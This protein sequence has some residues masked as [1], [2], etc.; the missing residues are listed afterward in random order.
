MDQ[1]LENRVKTCNICQQ[2]RPADN[3]VPVHPWEFP[4][5]PWVRFHLDYAGPVR[6]KMYLVL[7]DAYSK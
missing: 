5:R 4:K 3:P 1:E 7:I 2:N 6:G